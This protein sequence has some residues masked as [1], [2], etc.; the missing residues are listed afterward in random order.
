[1]FT[2][3]FRFDNPA[4][5]SPEGKKRKFNTLEVSPTMPRHIDFG[6][7]T[8]TL[9]AKGY[10]EILPVVV[11][12]FGEHLA[13]ISPVF[14]KSLRGEPVVTC[15][16][17]GLRQ[18]EVKVP[19]GCTG[20]DLLD[21]FSYLHPTSPE[22]DKLTEN[23]YRAFI[24]FARY[25]KI[26]GLF[27]SIDKWLHSPLGMPTI[28]DPSA[29]NEMSKF[30]DLVYLCCRNFEDLPITMNAVVMATRKILREFEVGT[31]L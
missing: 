11:K 19:D 15:N 1:M 28:E 8:V 3:P 24:A 21:I 5:E 7:P 16:D 26:K 30:S 29:L 18:Y 20:Q 10:N 25:Y 13:F 22:P 2:T 27:K 14:R 4:L 9:V 31:V 17:D 6:E 12:T 23:N